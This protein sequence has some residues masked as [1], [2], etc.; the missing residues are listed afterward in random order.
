MTHGQRR[1]VEKHWI[2]Q[3][4]RWAETLCLSTADPNGDP[5]PHPGAATGEADIQADPLPERLRGGGQ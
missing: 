1:S 5:S 4:A 3:A 2:G